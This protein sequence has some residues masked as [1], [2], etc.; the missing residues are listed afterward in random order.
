VTAPAKKK[1]PFWPIALAFAAVG[2]L[3]I[4]FV[5]LVADDTF[6]RVVFTTILAIAQV[7]GAIVFHRFVNNPPRKRTR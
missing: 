3:E 1:V 4:G 7:A 6:T 5:L 2:A